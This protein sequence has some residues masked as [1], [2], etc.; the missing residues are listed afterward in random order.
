LIVVYR[1]PIGD[2]PHTTVT[3]S[4]GNRVPLWFLDGENY[5]GE[6]DFPPMSEGIVMIGNQLAVLSESGAN[7]YQFG[8]KGPVDRVMLLDVSQFK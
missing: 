3:L 1:N 2:E 8:G 4:N 5:L 6:I 7:K